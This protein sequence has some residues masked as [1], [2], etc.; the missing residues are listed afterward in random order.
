MGAGLELFGRRRDGREFPVD[1]S[2]APLIAHDG[3]LVVAA[4]RDITEQKAVTAAQSAIATLVRSSHDA[5]V[6]L[7]LQG[8]VTSWNP[9]AEHLFGFT[10]AEV[11]GRHVSQL[12]PEDTSRDLEE[13]LHEAM[14]GAAAS[15]RDTQWTR[16]DGSRLDV[17]VS[18]SPIGEEGDKFTGFSVVL[19]DVTV[20]KQAEL[21]L[22]RQERWQAATSA[23]RLHLLSNQPVDE[24]LALICRYL[25]DLVHVDAALVLTVADGTVSLAASAGMADTPDLSWA[26]VPAFVTSAL[27]SG[28]TQLVRPIFADEHPVPAVFNPFRHW[29]GL[30]VPIPSEQVSSAAILAFSPDPSVFDSDTRSVVESL[31]GQSAMAFELAVARADRERLLLT[32]DRE[33]IARDLHDLVIQRLFATGMGLQGALRLIDNDRANERV[34]AAVNDLDDTIRE[35]RTAIFALETS[36]SATSGL[37]DEVLRLVD[38]VAKQLGF[39]PT[40]RFGGPV[41][42]A[43]PSEVAAQVLAAVREALSNVARHARASATAVELSVDDDVVLVIEDDGVGMASSDRES[44]LANLRSRAKELGGALSVTSSA[45]EGTRVEWRVPLRPASE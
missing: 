28:E 14:T 7:T 11:V 32:D 33:R 1:I 26:P 19:R 30:V 41:D 40:L 6:G 24:S 29:A 36:S 18:V 3:S 25:L 35:I 5:I 34:T 9:G 4:I 20:R 43:V 31:A 39:Q 37:R 17:A 42:S 27:E 15:P 21:Q 8:E 38:A 13:L 16:L 10:P 2:L 44:G 23:I 45:D 22:R 12:V